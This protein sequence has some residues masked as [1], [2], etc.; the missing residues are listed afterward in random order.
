MSLL[1]P[2][3]TI[4]TDGACSGNPGAGGYGAVLISGNHRKEIS[5]GFIRT[6]NQ[7]MELMAVI[8][9]LSL[10]R[11]ASDVQLFTDSN[12]VKQGITSWIYQWKQRGWMTAAKKP[13]KNRDLWE[14]LSDL[15]DKHKIEWHWVKGH[16]G[17]T[18]NE[19]CDV[20]ATQAVK[21]PSRLRD[22]GFEAR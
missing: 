5:Q 7:R 4:Y 21:A 16:A 11:R 10:L 12:Y 19:R 15:A 18:E 17:H 22:E 6:T 13:V 2:K 8:E 1:R 20:L 9:A 3:V 14:R